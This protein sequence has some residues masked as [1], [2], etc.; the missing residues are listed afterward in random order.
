MGSPPFLEP[1]NVTNQQFYKETVVQK[2]W[3]CVFFGGVS[4]NFLIYILLKTKYHSAWTGSMLRG[5]Q[6]Y[7]NDPGYTFLK[8]NNMVLLQGLLR[9]IGAQKSYTD[10]NAEGS[11]ISA[12]SW[13]FLPPFLEPKNV[14]NQQFYKETFVQKKEVVFCFFPVVQKQENWITPYPWV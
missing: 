10:Q 4:P 14:T 3:C 7:D 1:K 6:R 8:N 9:G 5:V 13:G 11:M 2:N 12:L